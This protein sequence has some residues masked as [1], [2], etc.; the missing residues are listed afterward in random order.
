MIRYLNVEDIK[1]LLNYTN[2]FELANSDALGG[3]DVDGDT[4]VDIKTGKTYVV[5]FRTRVLKEAN[6]K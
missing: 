6:R 2:I 3:M 1:K 5:N 4:F